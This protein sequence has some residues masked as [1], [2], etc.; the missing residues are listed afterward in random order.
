MVDRTANQL[1][2]QTMTATGQNSDTTV[3]R[4]KPQNTTVQPSHLLSRLFLSFADVD[5]SRTRAYTLGGNLTGIW[6]NLKGREP[7]GCVSPGAEYE[8]VRDQLIARLRAMRDPSDGLPIAT[9][10][11]RR[12][13]VYQGPYLDRAPDVL[14]ETR[15]EQYIGFGMQEFV[16]NRLAEPSPLFSGT[17]RRAGM[18]SLSGAPF[19]KGARLNAHQIV[20]LAPT[21]LH[22]LGYTIP[23]DMDGQVMSEALTAQ[24]HASHPIQISGESWLPS[25]DDHSGYSVEDEAAISERLK[26][27]GYL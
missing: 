15:D 2:V 18:V 22:L 7:Q 4:D 10:I 23:S 5:W 11:Y 20:D 8:Q 27:L 3:E 14:F 16:T 6:V 21:I 1:M 9:K 12:E 13:E 24:F 26:G 17:H 25:P 19:R